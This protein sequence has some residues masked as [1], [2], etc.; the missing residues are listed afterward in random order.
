M[1]IVLGVILVVTFLFWL[2]KRA[3]GK[4]ILKLIISSN[5]GIFYS[6]EANKL[7]SEILPIEH[8]R[9]FLHYL[10]HVLYILS[11][12]Q[13]Y[14]R[15]A[16]LKFIS[17]I[18]SLSEINQKNV[19]GLVNFYFINSDIEG[20]KFESTLYYQNINNRFLDFKFPTR[21]YLNQ[22]EGSVKTLLLFN[23]TI[24]D[25]FH[26]NILLESIRYLDSQYKNGVNPHDIKNSGILP[27]EAFWNR[28]RIV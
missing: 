6:V 21:H 26:L 25:E 15:I 1:K 20:I 11:D 9:H 8:V 16:I 23:T 2:Y 17:N 24:L 3:K 27:N 18:A 5:D 19:Q 14:E 4:P 10:T 12:Q 7:I 28:D 13:E 22:F